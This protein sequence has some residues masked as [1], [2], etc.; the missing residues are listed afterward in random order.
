MILRLKSKPQKVE[1]VT[2]HINSVDQHIRFTRKDINNNR[3]PFLDCAV[4][5]GSG[6]KKP[7]VKVSRKPTQIDQY[8]HFDSH[9]PLEH[10]LGVIRSLHNR[11]NNIHQKERKKNSDRLGPP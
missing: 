5:F 10:K 11:V 4:I 6:Q 8:L 9:H 7:T 1:R 2:D 3:L